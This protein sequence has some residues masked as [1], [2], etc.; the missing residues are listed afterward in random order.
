[1]HLHIPKH[2]LCVL[3]CV[4]AYI[5]SIPLHDCTYLHCIIISCGCIHP[6]LNVFF[7][8]MGHFHWPFIKNSNTYNT[9]PNISFYYQ[10]NIVNV[11]VFSSFVYHTRAPFEQR[12]WD[13]L[14]C[15]FLCVSW[16]HVLLFLI[17]FSQC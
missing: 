15:T 4:R 3:G 14:W 13:K 17:L 10:Y 16:M 6:K 7:L 9:H 1:M 11:F 12:I 5:I 8:T 2:T